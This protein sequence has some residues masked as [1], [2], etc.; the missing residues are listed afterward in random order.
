MASA[1]YRIIFKAIQKKELLLF[2]YKGF[3]RIAYAHVLG[4][5]NGEEKVLVF[6]VAGQSSQGLSSPEGV[7]R[8]PRVA[9]ITSLRAIADND[10]RGGRS[11]TRRN[12]CVKDVDIDVN[13]NA[14]QRYVWPGGGKS[15]AANKAASKKK[16]TKPSA[17]GKAAW[18]NPGAKRKKRKTANNKIPPR[19]RAKPARKR[20]SPA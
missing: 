20:K 14:K 9:E 18:R 17:K 11:H 5:T 6:Q 12:S 19:K 15:A 4:H 7:W 8:C 2:D 1:N 16:K 10:F 3:P 13:R